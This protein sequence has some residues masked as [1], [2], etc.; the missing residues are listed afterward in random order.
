MISV[1]AYHQRT[2]HS[3]QRYARSPE[4][5]DWDDQPDP[6]RR[7]DG[8]PVYTLPK[9]GRE[10]DVIWADLD[11]QQTVLPAELTLDNVGLLLELAFG[12][13]AWKQFG[14]DRWAL[15]CNPSSGNLHPSEAYLINGVDELM[16]QGVYHY[17][18]YDH[19]LEQRCTFETPGLQGSVLLGLSSVHWR[20]AW[21]YGE[22]AYRYCQLDAGHAL[23][24]LRYAAAT[25]GWGIDLLVEYSDIEIACLLGLDCKD[26]F[27]DKETESADWFCRIRYNNADVDP[28][29]ERSD[30]LEAVQRSVWQGKARSLGAYHMYHWVVIEEVALA[31]QKNRGEFD[32]RPDKFPVI[33]ESD[34]SMPVSRLIRQRR[35]AQHFDGAAGAISQHAFFRILSALLPGG[36]VPFDCWSW[37]AAVH[38][39]LFVHKVEELEPGIYCLPRSSQGLALLKSAMNPKFMWQETDAFA[40]LYLLHQADVRKAAKTLSC[41]QAIAS[42]SAFS[43]GMLAE[44]RELVAKHPWHYRRLFWE[45]GLLGQILYLEAE[46]AG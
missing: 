6:F 16:P 44:F 30:L 45:C 34:C 24:A 43:L 29:Q 8:C 10:L 1:T 18:S 40:G 20:E 33:A 12:L 4:T 35:S 32:N 11:Q 15:R 19:H 13:S 23:A 5:L 38:P 31:A 2:K 9:P 37:E 46:A 41:H 22:R 14:P 27:V 39:V 42:D 28:E 17:V 36:Q 7:F 3:L 25:L 21:K 26:E